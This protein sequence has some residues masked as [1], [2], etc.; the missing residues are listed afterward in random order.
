[1]KLLR[2]AFVMGLALA[3]TACATTSPYQIGSFI[4]GRMIALNDGK[5]Y[6]LQIQLSTFA[7]P[8]GKM[9]ATDPASGEIM[10]G[11]YT[12][13]PSTTYTQTARPGLLGPQA[14]GTATQ[15]SDTVPASA[16]LVGNK[17]TVVQLRMQIKAGT[18]PIGF[19]EG[20]DNHG[21]KYSVQF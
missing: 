5:L 18:P 3:T 15:I 4:P 20:E 7:N 12:A 11:Y 10:E 8:T 6:P 21:I 9:I 1:M 13:L 19:G 2:N 17:G 16:T 14:A